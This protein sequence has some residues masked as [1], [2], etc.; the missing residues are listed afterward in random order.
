MSNCRLTPNEQYFSYIMVSTRTYVWRDDI[1]C[2][3]PTR[4]V[5][6]Y[7]ACSLKQQFSGR[8][9]ALL[10]HIIL[11]PNR[12]VFP[13]TPECC[14]ISGEAANTNAIVSGLTR[15]VLE[16]TIYCTIT[17]TP[18]MQFHATKERRLHR[19]TKPMIFAILFKSFDFHA[20][21]YFWIHWLSIFWLW[22]Y[23]MKVIPGTCRVY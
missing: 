23:L 10:G 12:P 1:L 18:P 13:L 5:G 11:I 16:P 19:W 2:T 3:R 20:H 15:P 9:V 7:S 17:I 22:A 14:M 21:E 8:H 4:L 6:F